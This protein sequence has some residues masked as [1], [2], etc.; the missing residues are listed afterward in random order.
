MI[1]Q[2]EMLTQQIGRIAWLNAKLFSIL[3]PF[4]FL[5]NTGRHQNS[6]IWVEYP[7][8]KHNIRMISERMETFILPNADSLLT[9]SQNLS[10][11]HCHATSSV[12]LTLG[13]NLRLAHCLGGGDCHATMLSLYAVVLPWASNTKGPLRTWREVLSLKIKS[14][15]GWD[16]SSSWVSLPK[17]VSGSCVWQSA[18]CWG[19]WPL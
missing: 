6:R 8:V 19:R 10:L 18:T 15:N 14:P 3:I 4:Q 1:G 5:H 9:L 16:V 11:A 13:Q 2:S 12:L 17:K 7:H